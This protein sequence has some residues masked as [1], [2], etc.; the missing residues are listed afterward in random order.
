MFDFK[1][2]KPPTIPRFLCF[3]LV[4]GNLIAA[5]LHFIAC[6]LVFITL[7]VYLIFKSSQSVELEGV[8]IEVEKVDPDEFTDT[9]HIGEHLVRF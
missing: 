5:W 9:F 1:N 7:I 2:F 4:T 8:K 6:V 3:N